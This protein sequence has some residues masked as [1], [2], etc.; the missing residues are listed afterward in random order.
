M[1]PPATPRHAHPARRALVAGRATSGGGPLRAGGGP[2]WRGGWRAAPVGALLLAAALCLTGCGRRQ[3]ATDPAP[4]TAARPEASANPALA[5][6]KREVQARPRS[7]EARF[8]LGEQ[9][10]ADGQAAAAAAEYQRALELG[11]PEAAVLPPLA[12]AMVQEGRH[13][14]VPVQFADVRLADAEAEA[15]LQAALAQALWLMRDAV[16]AEAALRR[17]LTLSP[18]SPPA[19]RVQAR[20]AAQRGDGEAALATLDTLLGAHPGDAEA[21]ALRGDLLLR[22]GAAPAEALAA[23]RQ[24]LQARPTLVRVHASVVALLL[25]QGDLA[26]ARQQQAALQALAPRHPGTRLMAAHLAY[27]DGEHDRAR[28]AY[29]GLL[30]ERPDDPALL[31]A[32]GENELQAGAALQAEAYLAK[33]LA[34]APQHGLM[35]RLLAQAQLRLDQPARALMTLA[36]LVDAPRADPDVLALAAEARLRNGEPAAADALHARLAALQPSDPRLRALVASAG[37]GKGR[38]AAVLDELRAIAAADPGSAAD[39]ALVQALRQRGDADAALAAL[40]RWLRKQPGEPS[41]LLQRGAL[42][43]ARGD[44]DA[45]RSAFEQVLARVPDH[46]PAVAALAALAL[47]E[48]QPAAA[49]QRLEAHLA[50]HPRHGPSLLALVE[51]AEAG[52]AAP[53]EL[54]RQLAAAVKANPADPGLRIAQ[55][56]HHLDQHDDAAALAAAQAAT[57]ALPE[58]LALL[59][60]LAR[61]QLRAGQAS[62]ALASYG[63]VAA[64]QPRSARG[65]YGLAR[66]HLAAGDLAEARRHSARALALEPGHLAARRLAVEVALRGGDAPAALAL[67]RQRAQQPGGEA[68][69]WWLQAEIA[70]HQGQADAAVAALRRALAAAAGTPAAPALAQ[71]L[72]AALLDAGQRREADALAEQQLRHRPPDPGML[73][74]LGHRAQARGEPAEAERLYRQLLALQPEHVAALNNLALLQLPQR[75]ADAAALAARAARLAPAQPQVL[76]TLAQTQ[77]VAGQLDAAIA[78]QRRALALAPEDA[79]LRLRLADWYLAR[80]EKP[81]ARAEL[82]RLPPLDD[83]PALLAELRR[84]RAA[85]APVLPGR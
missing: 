1:P 17:A 9:L 81:Q 70:R 84:V 58:S 65:P 29:L 38:D 80:G 76:D 64:L 30:R 26:G 49:R 74:H 67:A 31:L 8:R 61:C 27:A 21:W 54:A 63:Q 18:G 40:D 73:F 5:A 22:R 6:L 39:Q 41:A 28:D 24:A 25:A 15:R 60:L 33:A 62:Q 47:R 75:S 16:G 43:A 35:R 71:R 83:R 13:A 12:E 53:A 36:P 66:A 57:A 69:G 52:G 50:R 11:H 4:A 37:L 7:G 78:T 2:R 51:L 44:T 46:F 20:L 56:R 23:Y 19:L 68:E 32:A 3:P 82:D 48:G 10:L 85:L 55:V 79:A 45:A 59:E 34:L 14:L 72:H 77:A 42:L